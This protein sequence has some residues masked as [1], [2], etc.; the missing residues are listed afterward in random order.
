MRICLL[1]VQDLLA[2][3][4]PESD[5]PC[6][7]RPFLP[8][9]EWHVELLGKATSVR[10]VKR[11]AREDFDLF[12]NL[13]DGSADED[14]PGIEV[15]RALE[16]LGVPFTGATSAFFE[17]SRIKMK[18]VAKRLGIATPAYVMAKDDDDVERAAE[19][20][21]FPLFV[22]HPSSHASVDLSRASRVATPVRRPLPGRSVDGTNAI[23]RFRLS[24]GPRVSASA[25]NA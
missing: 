23:S 22:K 20:L 6:D 13:C 18:R 7:P 16:R 21:A 14:Y 4:F 19:R 2:D 24:P 11:L 3:P 15:V 12:F 25:W 9:A 17:P 5:W 1:T 8:D 10:T